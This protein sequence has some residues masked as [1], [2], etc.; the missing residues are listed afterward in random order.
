[1]SSLSRTLVHSVWRPSDLLPSAFCL[2]G[3]SSAE[4]SAVCSETI[5]MPIRIPAHRPF[6]INLV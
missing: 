4:R 2:S 5:L 6:W 1:M 3:R